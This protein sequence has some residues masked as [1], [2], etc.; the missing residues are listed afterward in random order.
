MNA[1]DAHAASQTPLTRPPG[2]E[3]ARHEVMTATGQGLKLAVGE[4][5]V[6]EE[7]AGEHN[8]AEG[9]VTGIATIAP[10]ASGTFHRP[11]WHVA[12]TLLSGRAAVTVGDR[13]YELSQL[14]CVRIAAPAP[15][16]LANASDDQTVLHI[17]C[18]PADPSHEEAVEQVHRHAVSP[19]YELAA[20]AR[21]QDYFNRLLGFPALSGGYGLFAPGARLPCHLHGFDESITIVQGTATCVVEGRRY[22][23]S[24]NST[25][26]VPRR[27][28]HF[29]INEATEPIAMIWVYAGPMPERLVLSE[30]CCA[31]N[32]W[33]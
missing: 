25:A 19:W 10:G 22:S 31:A 27:R 5:V 16:I 29:F 8:G 13:K 4:G 33:M 9:L 26:L 1:K 11:H 32:P 30:R 20:G 17:A 6:F 15:L 7:L 23:L 12:A 21:F 14:D 24:N 3:P 2:E 28:C 18:G